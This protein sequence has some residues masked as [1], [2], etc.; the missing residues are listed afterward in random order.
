MKVDMP[1]N[2]DTKP[3][4]DKYSYLWFRRKLAFY[5]QW[6][7]C[8][9]VKIILQYLISILIRKKSINMISAK[10]DI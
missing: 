5:K 6:Q 4:N 1:S 3:I 10:K 2:N 8:S 9:N 7:G